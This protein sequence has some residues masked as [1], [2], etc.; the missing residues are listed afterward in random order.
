M[1][2]KITTL[3]KTVVGRRRKHGR[4]LKLKETEHENG[5]I[6]LRVK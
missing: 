1:E 4:K 2:L 6:A 5:H 3:S